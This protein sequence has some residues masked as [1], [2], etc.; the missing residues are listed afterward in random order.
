MNPCNIST[1]DQIF[2]LDIR[3]QIEYTNCWYIHTV[4]FNSESAR[5]KY[6]REFNKQ[7]YSLRKIVGR[8]RAEWH[9][10]RLMNSN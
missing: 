8:G 10:G 3:V 4:Y 5:R 6:V 2:Y 1:N 7:H 9:D